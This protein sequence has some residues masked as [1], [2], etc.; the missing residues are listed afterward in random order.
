MQEAK[1]YSKKKESEGKQFFVII[2]IIILFV[3]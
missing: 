3:E 1:M 2:N